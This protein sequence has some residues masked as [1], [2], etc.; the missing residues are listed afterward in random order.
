MNNEEKEEH[1][2]LHIHLVNEITDCIAES[3]LSNECVFEILQQLA[4]ITFNEFPDEL[5]AALCIRDLSKL[6]DE[7]KFNSE[8]QTDETMH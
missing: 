4:R 3:T 2:Q 8:Q 5:K 7:L 1:T 6:H